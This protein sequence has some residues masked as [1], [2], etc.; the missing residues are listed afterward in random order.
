VPSVVS[1]TRSL[2]LVAA[3]CQGIRGFVDGHVTDIFLTVFNTTGYLSA[4]RRDRLGEAVT[5]SVRLGA[6]P[7][8]CRPRLSAAAGGGGPDQRRRLRPVSML[9]NE[10]H[11]FILG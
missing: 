5:P 2:P 10:C 8:Q 4:S 9:R 6:G 1:D 7:A 11:D 3:G